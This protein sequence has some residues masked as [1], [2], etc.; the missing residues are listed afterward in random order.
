MKTA[1][2]ERARIAKA[3]ADAG[4]TVEKRIH[5]RFWNLQDRGGELICVAVYK[6]GAIAAGLA[7]ATA[8]MGPAA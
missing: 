6:K 7:I 5:T 2:T 3:L 4:L 8:R 1:N